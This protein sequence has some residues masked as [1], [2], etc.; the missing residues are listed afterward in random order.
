MEVEVWWWGS[1]RGHRGSS[2]LV[3]LVLVLVLVDGR[4][5]PGRETLPGRAGVRGLEGVGYVK[6]RALGWVIMGGIRQ[7]VGDRV[8][9][10]AGIGLP[11]YVRV[12]VGCVQVVRV[13]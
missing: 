11:V 13:R 10:G 8:V 2:K 3:G 12:V 9:V 6:G 5:G 4:W 1:R 7:E